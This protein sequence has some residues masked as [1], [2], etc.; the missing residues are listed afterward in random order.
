[1]QRAA[2]GTP[3]IPPF[4]QLSD[5]TANIIC[6]ENELSWC[7]IV[8]LISRLHYVQSNLNKIIASDCRI[9]AALHSGTVKSIQTADNGQISL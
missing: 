7:H 1:M 3:A 6:G 2:D 9:C 8:L 4:H 5:Q